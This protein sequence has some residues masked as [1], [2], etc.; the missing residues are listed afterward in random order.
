M[1]VRLERDF[2]ILTNGTSDSLTS[3]SR[4]GGVVATL[5]LKVFDFIC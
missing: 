3:K 1:S 2:K 4:F 5:K